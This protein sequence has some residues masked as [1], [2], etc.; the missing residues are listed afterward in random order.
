MVLRDPPEPDTSVERGV[1]ARQPWRRDQQSGYSAPH[2]AHGSVGKGPLPS[3]ASGGQGRNRAQYPDRLEGRRENVFGP[4]PRVSSRLA[5]RPR[6]VFLSGRAGPDDEG[7]G[8][9]HRCA[10]RDGYRGHTRRERNNHDVAG[11]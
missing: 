1:G 11:G 3:R 6:G 9:P 7:H 5:T 4:V 8:F 10:G 2:V